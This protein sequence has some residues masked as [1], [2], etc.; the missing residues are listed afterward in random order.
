[1]STFT[2]DNA[3]GWQI[4]ADEARANR[5]SVGKTVRV[6]EGK[7][8]GKVGEVKWHGVNKY[9]PIH[10]KSDASLAL[11][12]INGRTGYRVRVDTGIE[13]IWVDADKVDVIR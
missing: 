3:R 1:M 13:S 8:A 7:H 10:H 2:S 4:L 9:Y 6:T 11:M 12:Q 5:P